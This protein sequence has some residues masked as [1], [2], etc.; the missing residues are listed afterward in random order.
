MNEPVSNVTHI[1]PDRYH[2]A[3]SRIDQN[4]DAITQA[5]KRSASIKAIRRGE[6]AYALVAVQ[7]VD[8]RIAVAASE[9][10]TWAAARDIGTALAMLSAREGSD[11][12]AILDQRHQR[13]LRAVL[14]T[15]NEQQRIAVE[16]PFQCQDCGKRY[17]TQGGLTRHRAIRPDVGRKGWVNGRCDRGEWWV[18]ASAVPRSLCE[19][20]KGP[21]P[22][23]GNADWT[24]LGWSRVGEDT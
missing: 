20:I 3:A 4:P 12:N 1:R 7:H 21:C 18:E 11:V 13:R 5:F 9:G 6:V 23:C 8:G 24:W 10:I 2:G 17:K 19:E 14:E 22:H 16:R 15:Q